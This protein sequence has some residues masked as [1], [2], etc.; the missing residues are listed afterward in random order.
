[1]TI[2][3]EIET[4][5]AA[6][7]YRLSEM[8]RD[9]GWMLQQSLEYSETKLS[10]FIS[11]LLNAGLRELAI[12]FA[13]RFETTTCQAAGLPDDIIMEAARTRLAGMELN[14][15]TRDSAS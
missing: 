12:D 3:E 6:E 10:Q 11:A 5:Q 2:V 4:R 15:W 9:Y 8:E 13:S 1:M 7:S 14:R